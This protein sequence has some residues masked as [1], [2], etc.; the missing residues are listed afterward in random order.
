MATGAN[1]SQKEDE[2]KKTAEVTAELGRKL[3]ELR[4]AQGLTLDDAWTATKIQKKHLAVIEE[5]QLD[6]LPKGPFCRSFLRQYC[7]YLNAEDLWDRY[8]R[9]TKKENEALKAYRQEETEASYTNS[10]KIFRHKSYLWVYLIVILSL[11]AAAWIT[12]QYRGEITSEGTTPLEG[13]TASM[14]AEQKEAPPAASA[15]APV[16]SQ[17]APAPASVDLGWMDG[18]PPAAP[19]PAVSPSPAQTAPA[20]AAPEQQTPPA[21]A[22]PVIR[23]NPQGVV[24]IK[25]SVGKEVLFEGLLKPGETREYSPRADVPLRVRYGNPAKTGVSWFGA[26]EAPVGPA[27]NP[28]TRYYWYDGRIT[29]KS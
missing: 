15:D 18:K 1:S 12:W 19:A 13:G 26:A 16:Q 7:G 20:T 27:A 24:W 2:N 8:D 29:D 17:P 6:R 3:R 11:G 22:V 5:G 23:I 28:I 4:E 21:A 14:V 9:L 10:P 25:L